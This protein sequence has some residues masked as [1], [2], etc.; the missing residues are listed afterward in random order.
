MK[1]FLRALLARLFGFAAKKLEQPAAS[2]PA[3]DGALQKQE[4]QARA[5]VETQVKAGEAQIKAVESRGPG[6]VG[7]AS[8]DL[9]DFVQEV[10]RDKAR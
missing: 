9:D 2:G 7:G 3:D 8:D 5:N 10:E 1:A 6:R 4:K